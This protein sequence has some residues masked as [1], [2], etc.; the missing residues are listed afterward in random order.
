MKKDER[1][2]VLLSDANLDQY[3]IS[4]L[5]ISEILSSNSKIYAAVVFIGTIENQAAK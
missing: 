3:K 1:F 4:P 2:I 5:Y